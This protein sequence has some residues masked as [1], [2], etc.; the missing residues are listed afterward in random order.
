EPEFNSRVVPLN[1]PETPLLDAERKRQ[2]VS[3]SKPAESPA[4]VATARQAP[5]TPV[6][7]EKAIASPPSKAAK[8]PPAGAPAAWAIQLGSFS[9]AKNATALRDS[10]KKKGYVAFIET[11]RVDGKEITRVFVGPEL[12]RERA[13]ELVKKL[14]ADTELKGMVVQYPGS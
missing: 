10:L 12:A 1:A 6:T 9:S 13:E 8:A 7:K 5:A 3:E 14:Q 2:A 4:P 11:G